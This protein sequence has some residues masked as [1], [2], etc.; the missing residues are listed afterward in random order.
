[1]IVKNVNVVVISGVRPQFTRTAALIWAF[2]QFNGQSKIKINPIFIN[3][4]QHYDDELAKNQLDDLNIKF[5]YQLTHLILD[6][7]NILGSM[8]SGIYNILKELKSKPD[9]VIVSGDA[10]T[11]LSGAIAA[12]RLNIPIL[13]FEAGMRSGNLAEMEEINRRMVD[14]ISS[15]HYCSSKV[16]V[17]N[18]KREGIVDTVF[19][20]GD[21]SAEYIQAVSKEMKPGLDGFPL[22]EYILATLHKPENIFSEETLKN[23]LFTLRDQ[24]RPVVFLPHPRT[25]KIL[26]EKGLLDIKGVSYIQ[27]LSYTRM[28]AAMKGCAY[29]V[30]D[31]GGLHKEAYYLKKRCLV[32]RDVGGWTALIDANI[33][34]RIGRTLEDIKLGL[35]WIELAISKGEYSS[36]DNDDLFKPNASFDALETLVKITQSIKGNFG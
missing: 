8:I 18:L 28:L 30:T 14:H 29:I 10:T 22:G 21:I 35:D 5:D 7:I 32:R 2:R 26:E 11:T 25:R 27:P 20:F 1:M 4:G 17:E 13:H 16:A 12:A 6:P 3:S 9:W 34:R 19:W 31:S 24:R 15:L 23:V 36:L 33:H